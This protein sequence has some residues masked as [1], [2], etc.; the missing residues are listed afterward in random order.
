MK[1][2]T[3]ILLIATIALWTIILILPLF[4]LTPIVGTIGIYG[5]LF[6]LLRKPF[7]A[8]IN[9]TKYWSEKE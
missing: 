9:W 7:K 4:S 2:A 8:F 5:I 3:K 1:K 6:I